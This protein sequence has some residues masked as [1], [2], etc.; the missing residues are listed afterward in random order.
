MLQS[1]EA[2]QVCRS[3]T[4]FVWR[5]VHAFDARLK[6]LEDHVG[7]WK[8]AGK[9]LR[10]L[11]ERLSVFGLDQLT[12]VD[13]RC[14]YCSVEIAAKGGRAVQCFRSHHEMHSACP[15]EQALRMTSSIVQA[16]EILPYVTEKLGSSQICTGKSDTEFELVI[17]LNDL[18]SLQ[19]DALGLSGVTALCMHV[20]L[21]SAIYYGG[22]HRPAV[23][24]KVLPQNRCYYEP[25]GAIL[26]QITKIS[27][28][29]FANNWPCHTTKDTLEFLPGLYKYV[30]AMIPPLGCFC[31]GLRP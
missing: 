21:Q 22:Y 9:R 25:Y 14:A 4:H 29:F 28:D 16:K 27:E 10:S 7:S 15:G 12:K 31:V 5:L 18:S 23:E 26:S 13:Y 2:L 8:L 30:R 1:I 20:R 6:F 11:S 17:Q 3:S 19:A 24:F